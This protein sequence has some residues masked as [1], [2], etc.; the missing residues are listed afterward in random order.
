MLIMAT[1]E[2]EQ[3][4]LIFKNTCSTAYRSL[5]QVVT[6]TRYRYGRSRF[7]SRAD[8]I[9]TVS[10]TARHRCDVSLEMR[11]SGAKLRT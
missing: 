11:S 5:A 1:Q 7:D 10:P 8:Q 9:G 2:L 6:R 4:E 3:L